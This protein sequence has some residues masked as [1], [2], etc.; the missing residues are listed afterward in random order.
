MLIHREQDFGMAIYI[1]RISRG[2]TQRDLAEQL[3]C[4]PTWISHIESGRRIPSVRF[5]LRA[6]EILRATTTVAP[7]PGDDR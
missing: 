1:L 2:L 7:T 6:M 4:H 5:W 3:D